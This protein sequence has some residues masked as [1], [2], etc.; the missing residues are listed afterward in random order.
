MMRMFLHTLLHFTFTI[1]MY[2]RVYFYIGWM[3]MFVHARV[4][5]YACVICLYIW[6]I[7]IYM[8][9]LFILALGPILLFPTPL[10]SPLFPLLLLST[11]IP[12]LPPAFPYLPAD[13]L[14]LHYSH[15]PPHPTCPVHP[16]RSYC[17]HL[18]PFILFPFG[19][20]SHIS[21]PS[22]SPTHSEDSEHSIYSNLPSMHFFS[23]KKEK[24]R[25]K[26]TVKVKAICRHGY[27]IIPVLMVFLGFN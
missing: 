27:C 1:C 16:Y 25:V 10:I 20:I 6:L 22:V 5:I 21:L 12:F 4:C 26:V 17:A 18:D 23:G 8:C 7:C 24:T 2:I 13:Y 3:Y 11:S 19:P 15:P 9:V 14:G